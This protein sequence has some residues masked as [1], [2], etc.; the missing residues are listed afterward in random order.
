MIKVDKVLLGDKVVIENLN[1]IVDSGTSL[2][3]GS[4]DV[5]GDLAKISVDSSCKNNDHLPT[6][7]FV[8]DGVN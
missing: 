2:M 3:V 7:T 4:A 1:G 6:V 8:I 5:L